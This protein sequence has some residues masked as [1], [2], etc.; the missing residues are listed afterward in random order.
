MLKRIMF[1]SS[2]IEVK[3]AN[4][5]RV[6][7]SG[8]NPFTSDKIYFVKLNLT[9]LDSSSIVNR[10]TLKIKNSGTTKNKEIE[11]IEWNNVNFENISVVN[12]YYSLLS[13][14]AVNTMV[15]ID[16]EPGK[17]K[18]VDLTNLIKNR[19][20]SS[21]YD[22]TMMFAVRT[23]NV[24]TGFQLEFN[25][26]FSIVY[27]N[28][29]EKN[30]FAQHK[31]FDLG[32]AGTLNVDLLDGKVIHQCPTMSTLLS[33]P[34]LSYPISIIQSNLLSQEELGNGISGYFSKVELSDDNS[35]FTITNF[36]GQIKVYHLLT[37]NSLNDLTDTEIQELTQKGI[38]TSNITDGVWYCDND[39]TYISRYDGSDVNGNVVQIIEIF[40]QQ[41]NKRVYWHY[42]NNQRAYLK[43]HKTFKGDSIEYT[44]DSSMLLTKMKNN[45]NE[46]L[47]FT[48]STVNNKK[49][50]TKI[51]NNSSKDTLNI[52]YDTSSRISTMSY[53]IK[54]ANYI[55]FK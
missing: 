19:L 42:S 53:L 55:K 13:S 50:L 52:T 30:Q 33:R 31:S 17:T 28:A 10:A 21:N 46:E 40:D 22:N 36:D 32:F 14:T 41:N 43:E 23:N 9:G 49:M 44:Y 48:Y 7:T 3:Q 18:N 27:T 5:S 25:H 24:D 6:L 16:V 45:F 1:D 26:E 47:A 37:S 29:N 4:S 15:K 54:G 51:T 38:N 12:S 39:M 8:F 35:M 34:T 2:T 11:I 20:I